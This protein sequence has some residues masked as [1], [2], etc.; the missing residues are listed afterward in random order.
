MGKLIVFEGIDGSG[1]STQFEL[2]CAALS[3]E[4]RDFL[5][6]RFPRYDNPSAALINMYLEGD[7]GNDPDAVNAY[8]A[9]SFFAVDRFASYKQDWGDYYN[10]GGLILT[11]RYTTSNAIH[12]GSKLPY[13]QRASFFKWLYE[14][15]FDLMRLPAPDV[16]LFMDID[17]KTAIRRIKQRQSNAGARSDIHENDISYLEH[18]AQ[19]GEQAAEYFGWRKVQCYIGEQERTV[20]DIHDEIYSATIGCFDFPIMRT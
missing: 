18:C 5:R 7:F 13:E 4:S 10:N 9:S 2:L 16:V 12:Q 14:Y 8:A 3:R 6:V 17:V 19:C 20:N 15:E 11:D 1:K